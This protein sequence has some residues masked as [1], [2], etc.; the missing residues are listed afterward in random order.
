MF[1]TVCEGTIQGSNHQKKIAAR[2]VTERV[3]MHPDDIMD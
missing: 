1:L 3:V 2:K